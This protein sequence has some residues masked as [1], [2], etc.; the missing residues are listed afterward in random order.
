MGLFHELPCELTDS[1]IAVC[2]KNAKQVRRTFNDSLKRQAAARELK[3]KTLR[4][5]KINAAQEGLMD[6]LYLHQQYDSPR[7]WRTEEQALEN[8]EG[9]KFKKDRMSSIK[10]QILIRYLGLGWIEAHHPWSK[11]GHGTFSPTELL[12]HFVKVVLPLADIKEVTNE[13]P[14]ELPGLPNI[15]RIGT[16]AQ[17]C[18]ELEDALNSEDREFRLQALHKREK[19]EDDGFG[20]QLMEMQ[21]NIWPVKSLRTSGFKIDKLFEYDDDE[22]QWC[23]G[24]VTGFISES[25][26]KHVI[27]KVKWNKECLKEG[28]PEIT[29]EKLI[30]T[31]WN[32][33]TQMDG[34]WREDLYHKIVKST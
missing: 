3:Q 27:V 9:M 24:K 14:L 16:R 25:K 15:C 19:L 22:L 28:D 12:D 17:D 30:R 20:D 7:C 8:F 10:E 31:K 13:P 29:R 21:Q 32:P 11:K 33:E 34:A 4:D 5:N 18:I 1:L 6:A 26:N 2:K 23:Q